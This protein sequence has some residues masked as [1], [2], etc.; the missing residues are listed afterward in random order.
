VHWL[1]A[2]GASTVVAVDLSELRRRRALEL[3]ADVVVDPASASTVDAVAAITGRGTYGQ[4]ARADAAI[5]C[6]GSSQAFADAVK[7]ARGGARLVIAAL[8]KGNVEI[9][10][11]RIVQKELEIRGS[12]AYRDEFPVVIR[13]LARGTLD[14]EKLISHTF[15]LAGVQEAFTMQADPERSIKVTVDPHE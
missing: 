15:A 14:A 11:D 9:R 12:L 5:E 2:M 8:Y 4:G 3:G 13:E 7:V 6:S 1:R 10:P